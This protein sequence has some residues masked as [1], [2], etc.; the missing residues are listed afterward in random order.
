MKRRRR[1]NNN[2][3]LGKE[4]RDDTDD[5]VVYLTLVPK[6]AKEEGTMDQ[7][8]LMPEGMDEEAARLEGLEGAVIATRTA[9]LCR[10]VH[11]LACPRRR[12]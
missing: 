4:E 2:Q 6:K 12:P 5:F 1:Q 10:D 8:P 9:S 3:N 11:T 7:L